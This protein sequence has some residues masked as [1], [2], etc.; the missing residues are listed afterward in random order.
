M[1]L[2]ISVDPEAT[3]LWPSN[4]KVGGCDRRVGLVQEVREKATK[5]AWVTKGTVFSTVKQGMGKCRTRC[6]E[7]S[8]ETEIGESGQHKRSSENIWEWMSRLRKLEKDIIYVVWRWIRLLPTLMRIK[9]WLDCQPGLTL[10]WAKQ[11]RM[12]TKLASGADWWKERSSFRPWK[13]NPVDLLS[14]PCG[15]A[16]G[17]GTSRDWLSYPALFSMDKTIS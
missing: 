9:R 7:R 14:E 4:V 5:A 6:Q 17:Q 1:T 12:D 13:A 16:F 8:L 3:S 2:T 15:I 10:T 11:L